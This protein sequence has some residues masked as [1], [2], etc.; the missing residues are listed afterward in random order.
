ML[1]EF[2]L[3][4]VEEELFLETYVTTLRPKESEG[5]CRDKKKDSCMK[6]VFGD[7]CNSVMRSKESECACRNKKMIVASTVQ[8]NPVSFPSSMSLYVQNLD[9]VEYYVS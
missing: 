9:T 8:H 1:T 7:T 2:F 6:V 3:I 5:A 4:L